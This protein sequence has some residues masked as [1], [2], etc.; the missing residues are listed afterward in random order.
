MN[1]SSKE[2][3]LGLP[4]EQLFIRPQLFLLLCCWLVGDGAFVFCPAQ[5]PLHPVP[6][7]L[8]HEVLNLAFK[9]FK[10]KEG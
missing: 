4:P 10:H 3:A 7:A 2:F 6:D 5:I 9:H 1:T 8:V